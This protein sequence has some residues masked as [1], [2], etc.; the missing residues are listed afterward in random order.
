MTHPV[1]NVPQQKIE[2]SRKCINQLSVILYDNVCL[3]QSLQIFWKSVN[4]VHAWYQ[5][6]FRLTVE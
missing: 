2:I 4:L 6:E 1:D 3:H 5:D